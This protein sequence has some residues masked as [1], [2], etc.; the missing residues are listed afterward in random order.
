MNIA[1]PSMDAQVAVYRAA[2]AAAGVDARTRRHGRG[3]RHRHPGRRPD[4]V[5]QPRRG[6]RHRRPRA[7]SASVKTNF[8]HAQSA[9]GCRRADEGDP[10]RCSTAWF[11]RTCTSPG[12][13]RSSPES[14]PSSSCRRRSHRGPRTVTSAPARG[15]VVLRPVRNQC[16]RH[17][18]AG[19]RDQAPA[20]RRAGQPRSGRPAG[21]LLFPLSSTS[22]D[23]LRRTAGRLADWVA[24]HADDVELPD[25]AY[26]LARR[27]AHRPVR[28]ARHRRQPSRA[29][30]GVCARSPTG[31]P[32]TSP[33]SGTT[34]AVRCGC[35]PGR[36]RSGRR[37][38]PTCWP[39]NRFSPPRS[40]K[41]SR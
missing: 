21:A 16:A 22:A 17:F 26:T 36:V 1:T 2:L 19:A 9:A 3:A 11:R 37:W 10:G 25:L 31:T 28:T 27:R 6:L 14:R 15:G 18:R 24:E 20:A 12:C 5:Q 13:P 29:D 32:R 23:E 4:R 34:T 8:G 30:R 41:S 38:A 35:S 39:P 40:R 7:C 33:R